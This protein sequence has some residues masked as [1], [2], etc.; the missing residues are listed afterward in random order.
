[1]VIIMNTINLEQ[2]NILREMTFDQVLF[3]DESLSLFQK[4]LLI[5]N[6]TVTDLLRLYTKDKI[7]VKKLNQEMMTS[8]GLYTS[9]CGKDKTVLKREILLATNEENLI[10]ADSVFIMD[11]MSENIQEQLLETQKPIGTLWK[12]EKLNTYRDIFSIRL[13][14]CEDIASHFNIEAKTPF[15][16]RSYRIDNYE[17]TLGIITEKFPITYFRGGENADTRSE[18]TATDF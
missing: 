3:K 6:G 7:K 12:E 15:L 18:S 5:T 10:Y 14:V 11:N 1:M 13:E 9:L 2:N 16:V 8:D 17:N 4:V